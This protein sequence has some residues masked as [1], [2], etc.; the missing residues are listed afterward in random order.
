MKSNRR[1]YH[2]PISSVTP[3]PLLDPYLAIANIF[4]CLLHYR[5]RYSKSPT[6]TSNSSEEDVNNRDTDKQS[7]NS[8]KSIDSGLSDIFETSKEEDLSSPGML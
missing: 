5:A 7:Y 4:R 2:C 1:G 3:L 8:G 6:L